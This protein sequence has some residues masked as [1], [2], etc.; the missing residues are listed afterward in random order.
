MCSELAI[1]KSSSF[2]CLHFSQPQ[3]SAYHV[4]CPAMLLSRHWEPITSCNINSINLNM[5]ICMKAVSVFVSRPTHSSGGHSVLWG[6]S[7]DWPRWWNQEGVRFKTKCR[8][9]GRKIKWQKKIRE[10]LLRLSAPERAFRALSRVES[11][12]SQLC[13]LNKFLEQLSFARLERMRYGVIVELH[14]ISRSYVRSL[15]NFQW[16]TLSLTYIFSIATKLPNRD[17]VEKF[18]YERHLPV[19]QT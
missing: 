4:H 19:S 9:P 1:G 13:T 16:K 3:F 5:A 18:S 10:P 7:A 15:S 12:V 14:H 11:L 8:K 2:L 6:L 17:N